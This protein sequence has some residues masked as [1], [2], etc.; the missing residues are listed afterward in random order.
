MEGERG[1]WPLS[2]S[3]TRGVFLNPFG[4]QVLLKEPVQT[5]HDHR[6]AHDG[7]GCSHLIITG[8]SVEAQLPGPVSAPATPT[9][10]S[11]SPTHHHQHPCLLEPQG[12]SDELCSLL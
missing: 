7:G 6:E 12:Y 2:S 3:V 8:Q 11:P 9:W 1:S 4:P 10:S 5:S